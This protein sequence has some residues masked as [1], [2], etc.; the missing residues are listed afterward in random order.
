VS[1]HE[2]TKE[3][4]LEELAEIRRREEQW[5]SVV[6]NTPVFVALVDR[7]GTIQYLNHLA[8]GHILEDTIGK[9]VYGFIEPDYREVARECIERV[10]ATGQGGFFEPV[11]AGPN[12]S[13]SWYETYAGPVKANG[14][15]VAAALVS[16]DITRQKRAEAKLRESEERFKLFMDNSPAIAWLK[17]EQGRYV[18]VNPSCARRVGARPE[19]R[20]GK[21]DFE[22][23]PLATAEQFWK[24]DQQVLFS[25]QVVEV[26]E[27][28]S[29]PDGSRSC[30]RNFKFPFQDSKGRRFVGGVGID[31]TEL[32]RAEEALQKAHDELEQRVE[33]RTAELSKTNEQLAVFRKF[34]EASGQAFGMSYLDCKVAYVNPAMLKLCGEQKIEDVLGTSFLSYYP[35]QLREK[36]EREMFTGLER[37]G[38]WAGELT[39]LTAAGTAK[40]VIA[41][42]FQILDEAGDPIYLAFV[43]TD[44]TELKQA[45]KALERERRTLEHMLQASDHERQLIAYDIHDG[46][47]QEL[48]GAIMQFQ[49]YDQFQDTKPDEA[50]KAYDGGVKLLRQGHSEA[51]RLISGVRPPILDESG[52][53]AAIAHMV[54]EPAFDQGPKIVFRSGVTFNRLA[55]V[56]ENV[57]YRIAQEGLSNARNHSKSKKIVV[58]LTQRGERLRIKIQDW[59]VGFDPKKVQEKRFGL[60]GIRERARLLGG[61]CKIQSKPGEGTS[62]VVELPVVEQ[63]REE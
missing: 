1:D 30:C 13:L 17:D 29:K 14:Q 62:V 55:P 48:A 45:Q 57:I 34:A 22:L 46:L 54:H 19:D 7:A 49:V 28:S 42:A 26:I 18:Y 31:I 63:R 50:R 9:S 41:S 23:W 35:G 6:A 61:K 37:E 21:T 8:P 12:G 10:F 5:R 3:Q 43:M 58:S 33:Q 56:V 2:K 16:R 47:A 11:A 4:L 25:G 24:N 40:T 36:L 38:K 52:V 15:V 60:D 59:G 27:E 51:R 53:V 44:I 20:I 39:F 32:K